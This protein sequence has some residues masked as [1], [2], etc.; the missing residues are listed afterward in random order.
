MHRGL[1]KTRLDALSRLWAYKRPGL[2]RRLR[3]GATPAA[4]RAAEKKFGLKLPQGLRELYA[5][6]DGAKDPYEAIEGYYGWLSLARAAAQKKM[7][8]RVRIRMLDDGSWDAAW[9]PVLC[10]EGDLLCV[11]T[12]SGEVFEWLNVEGRVVNLAP[13]VDAWLRAHIAITK[14]A[15]AP[16]ADWDAVVDAFRGPKAR[17]I[18]REQSPGYPKNVRPRGGRA[19]AR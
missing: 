3:K 2:E 6:H 1:A 19:S 10:C 4:L 8:E 17:R 12:R 14:S 11:D 18:R 5:W 9:V 13:S 7:L 15:K 16:L